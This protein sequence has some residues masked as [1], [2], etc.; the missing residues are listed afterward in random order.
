MRQFWFRCARLRKFYVKTRWLK[1]EDGVQLQ[2]LNFWTRRRGRWRCVEPK[3]HVVF[4]KLAK[5]FLFRWTGWMM[6]AW[7]LCSSGVVHAASSPFSFTLDEP[8]KTSAGVFAPDGT[9][10]R[11]LWSKVRYFSAGTYSNIWDGLDDN[12]NAAPAGVYQI[13]VLQHNTEYV[14]DGAVGNTSAELSGP[15]VH[16]GFYPM[17][18]MAI[19]GT[20]AF[21]VS[22]YNEGDY[23]FRN[24]STS[25]PQRVKI[26]WG[27]DGQPANV[28]DRDW[29]WTATDGNWVYF[30][31]DAAT[32]PNNTVSNDHPGFVIASKVGVSSPAYSA[33]FTQGIPIVNGANT[34][35]TYPNGIYVG[36]QPGLSGLAVQQN[37]N[38]L[39]VSVAPDNRVYLL[40]KLSGAAVRNFS[41]SSPGR[42]SF[43]SDGSLWVISG[44]N[45]ICYTNLNSNPSA[46]VTISNFREP[47]AVAV[48]PTNASLILVA[49]G[50]SSQQIKAFNSAGTSLWTYGL[51]GG[52]QTN[53][54]AVQTNKFWFYDAES[55]GTFLCFAPDGSFW[56]GDGGNYRA[57]H[58]SAALNYIEQIMYQPHSYKAC[59]DQNNPSRVFNQFLE[60]K[61]D[62]TKPLQQGWTLANNWQVGVDPIHISWNEGIY[63]VTTFTN[64]RTYALIDND[65]YSFAFSEL[66]ELATNQ[67]RFTGIAP[68]YG[69]SAR[70]WI[71][72]G[73][74][75]SARRTTIGAATWY[76]TTLS[77]FD[78][79]NNPVWNPETLIASASQGATDPVPRGSS[80]GNIRATISTNNIL[81]SFDQS[82]NNGWHLGGIKVGTSKWLWKA[83][84]S[85]A[86]MNGCGNYENDNGITYAGNTLQA[87][88]RQVI[89]GYHGEFFRSQGQASQTMHF[90]DDGLFVG[91][92]G[93]SNI[94][95]PSYEGVLAGKAGNGHCPSL[96]K[97]TSGDYYLW[98]NDES[99][100][101]P[102]RWHLV[103]ARNIRELTGSGTLGSAITLTNQAYGFPA[104]VTG[105]NGNQS[106][107]LSWQPVQGAASYNIR[108]SQI[109]GG[110]YN[111]LAANTTNSD[112]V[113]SGLTN[114]Q[115]YYFAVTAIQAGQE[116][117][118]SEQVEVNPFDT[119]Q[120]VLCA[121][122]VSEGGPLRVIDVSSSA[123][124]SGQ[125][126]WIGAEHYTG[127]LNPREL[128][129]Y[130]YGNLQ[131]E[132]VGTKGYVIYQYG[133]SGTTLANLLP[134]FSVANWA[135]FVELPNL[136]RQYQVDN[137]P[138]ANRG[139]AAAPVGTI[140]IG[141]TDTNYHYL[142][143]VSPSQFNNPR[144]FTMRLTSTNNTSAAYAVNESLGYSHIFQFMFKGNATLYADAT[145][146]GG[147]MVQALFLDNAP[148]TY[149]SVITQPPPPPSVS[150]FH[151]VGP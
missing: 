140:G 6:G 11:T 148:V 9:L 126:S 128:D 103:N 98:V 86:W 78:S 35:S 107:E 50:G 22:G 95:H 105:K 19:A 81:I 120:T 14:W 102:Q 101:G 129:D 49:D 28:Y 77:G 109:N 144:Q 45:V 75:G 113:I 73:P 71:S 12:G 17:R 94:G 58:F 27:A 18:D 108:Y 104:V 88:D 13:K 91:Q 150:G 114:G 138:G 147:A 65:T 10:I 116:G 8:C 106:G 24:F 25:D 125:P 21:Y 134:G 63:E 151:R 43:S 87:V 139:L 117:I 56:V 44:N 123:P 99:G 55:D 23:D 69:G 112:Y 64:G 29:K 72:L 100:H 36:T 131:N 39:A 119:T 111:I 33:Y 110:P 92:F 141:V 89:Y 7:L 97:T 124:I 149:A 136:Q 93:E 68:A 40:D 42:L 32:D 15:T 96:I 59:V 31:C 90:Y 30:A 122:S 132:T 70:G 121:G 130:G 127:V 82:L 60:F 61:V 38:L 54:V 62:Y 135:G 26:Q 5:T 137:V 84:P 74:D 16:T 4:M 3:S 83:S 20:N 79:S 37:G 76:E 66:C 145:G 51:A 41:V 115:T 47:L 118:P 34:N 2:F 142:T 133:G 80:F 48:S 1:N 52:Y 46:A 53:G 67:L 85:A 143:V 146:G 57:L